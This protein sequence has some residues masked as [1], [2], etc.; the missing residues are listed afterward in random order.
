MLIGACRVI[1]CYCP[2]H[3][4]T[5]LHFTPSLLH[6]FTSSLLHF[7]SLHSF[8]PSLLHSFTSSGQ[9][10]VPDRVGPRPRRV[11]KKTLLGLGLTFVLS[12]SPAFPGAVPARTCRVACSSSNMQMSLIS[13]CNPILCPIHACRYLNSAIGDAELAQRREDVLGVPRHQHCFGSNLTPFSRLSRAFLFSF[14]AA[15]GPVTHDTS[16]AV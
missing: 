5:S 9:V 7:T 3:F 10:L 12:I 4:F 6:S 14:S 16:H 13:A 11:T 2:F 8:T 1:R 15:H